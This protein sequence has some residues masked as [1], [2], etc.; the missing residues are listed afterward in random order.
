ML[1][2]ASTM[3]IP[4]RYPPFGALIALT[5]GLSFH[6]LPAEAFQLPSTSSCPNAR[7]KL[8]ALRTSRPS[9]PHAVAAP[10]HRRRILQSNVQPLMAEGTKYGRG[11]EIWPPTNEE[12]VALADSFPG[13]AIP[14]FAADLLAG[15]APLGDA[16]P[17]APT[18][19]A[20][21]RA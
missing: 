10:L 21:G 6:S 14:A 7:P 18:T 16:V 3:T 13:G 1:I 11:S 20:W 19:S 12:P 4:R 5:T 9:T 17:A 8:L 2:F 15:D